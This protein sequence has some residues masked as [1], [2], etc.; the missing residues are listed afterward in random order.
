M[1]DTMVDGAMNFTREKF[2][3]MMKLLDKDGDGTVDK[4]EYHAVYMTMF[5]DATEDD[6]TKVWNTIDDDGNG[7]LSIA[8]L[9]MFYGFNLDDE[10]AAEMTDE[11][12]LEA[13]RM[14]A[15]L[16]EMN[17]A[18]EKQLRKER[19]E[20]K[21]KEEEERAA[22][23]L[24]NERIVRDP[25][26]KVVDMELKKKEDGDEDIVHMLECCAL[27]E[28]ASN[29]AT[30]MTV[31][32][33]LAKKINVRV[34]CDKGEMPLHK[35]ARVKVTDNNKVKYEECFH[36]II[37]L[38]RAQAKEAGKKSIVT[39]I[40]HQDKAGKTPLYMAIEHKNLKL[41]SLLYSLG[42]EGPDSL[43]VNWAGWTVMHA[44]VNTDDLEVLKKLV[45]HFTPQRVRLLLQSPDKTGREP[46]HIAAYKSSENMVEYLLNIG[47]SNV[48]VDANGNNASKLA[49]RAGRRKSKELI[50][51]GP[52]G[53]RPAE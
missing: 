30:K 51:T 13:L 36:G 19:E 11:Q 21:A 3:E 23:G 28:L 2:D 14:Q 50:E 49:D 53:G 27:G 32:G 42:G 4:D 10:S 18:K 26:V 43:L 29:D 34:E 33:F 52:T 31:L 46:L 17:E 7:E 16:V 20:K 41:M 38:M 39:D 47:G 22:K 12:I 45:D 37:E 5:P 24:T 40:N 44:A 48:R 9:A 35:F 15:A 1:A 8:E 6:F 25:T